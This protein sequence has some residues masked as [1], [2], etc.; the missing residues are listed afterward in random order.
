MTGSCLYVG[1]VMHR[2]LQ[3]FPHR[4]A[5]RVFSLLLDLDEL[6]ALGA[7]LR[8]FSHNRLNLLSFHD[9]DHGA[10]DGTPLRPWVEGLLAEAGIAADGAIRLLCF[11]RILGL[12]FNPLAI[13]FC[14]R[15]DGSLAAILYEVRNTFGD[16][17][18]YLLEA[19]AGGVRGAPILQGCAKQFHVSP[20]LPVDGEYHFRLKVPDA[21]LS[22]LIRHAAGGREML[23]ASQTGR[24]EALTDRRLL[25]RFL[26]HPLMTVKVVAA[27]HWQALR[28]WRKGARFHR[29]PGSVPV[30]P[31]VVRASAAD[32][33]AA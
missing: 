25:A 28:L 24:R 6:P 31:T 33:Q 5:Y 14:H 11:P 8:L 2:R 27:I 30:G 12:V 4:F 23:I 20:F 18:C 21:S 19:P 10:R 26:S 3:P 1:T 22:I 29:H 17:H 7:G 16:K 13:F 9:S 15:A 32:R